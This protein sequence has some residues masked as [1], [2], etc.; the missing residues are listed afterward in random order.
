M[1]TE[2]CGSRRHWLLHAGHNQRVLWLSSVQPRAH[3][4]H[5]AQHAQR[6]RQRHSAWCRLVVLVLFYQRLHHS[7]TGLPCSRPKGLHR[8]RTVA[9]RE[10]LPVSASI[11][12]NGSPPPHPAAGVIKELGGVWAIQRLRIWLQVNLRSARSKHIAACCQ[13]VCGQG[14]IACRLSLHPAT[15]SS[16][17]SGRQRLCRPR[18]TPAVTTHHPTAPT[19]SNSWFLVLSTPPTCT[20]RCLASPSSRNW[21]SSSPS[22]SQ[23][24]SRCSL[25]QCT[26]VRV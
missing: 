24:W 23:V 8:P 5:C 13:W 16:G 15:A 25:R 11:T 22:V 14:S 20:F 3:T 21:C 12:G 9:V 18:G 10:A 2:M 1:R 17:A 7:S 26:V 6:A 4:Q 19:I